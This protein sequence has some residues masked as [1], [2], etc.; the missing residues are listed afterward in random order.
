MLATLH[1]D[2]HKM[3][4]REME[5]RAWEIFRKQHREAVSPMPKA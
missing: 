5:Q 1:C 2:W 4:I 3:E